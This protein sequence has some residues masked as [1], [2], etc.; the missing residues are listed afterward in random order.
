MVEIGWG[1]DVEAWL[2]QCQNARRR[3]LSA[4]SMCVVG[5]GSEKFIGGERGARCG[6]GEHQL[7]RSF[8]RRADVQ[9]MP[10]HLQFVNTRR[11]TCHQSD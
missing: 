11:R 6:A 9:S 5:G 1:V 8:G 3:I 7:V 10:T 4:L 2:T